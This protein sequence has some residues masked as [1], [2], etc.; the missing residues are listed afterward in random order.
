VAQ[1]DDVVTGTRHAREEDRGFIG[2][3]AGAGEEALL[4]FAGSDL[5]EF[6]G[7]RDD[8]FVGEE[9]RGVLELIDLR[10]DL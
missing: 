1:R 6:F 10:F 8:G 2:F 3:R 7:Q 4:Q 5:S 9:C